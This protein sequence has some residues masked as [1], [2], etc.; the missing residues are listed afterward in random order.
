MFDQRNEKPMRLSH[1]TPRMSQPGAK[2]VAAA[3][4]RGCLRYGCV[5]ETATL[6]QRKMKS[7]AMCVYLQCDGCGKGFSSGLRKED[8]YYFQN[9]PLWDEPLRQRF[10]E[11]C[12]V[13]MDAEQ[14]RRDKLM[15][16]RQDEIDQWWFWYRFEF[17]KSDEWYALRDKVLKRDK[18]LCQ[19]CGQAQATQVHHET[20]KF[21]AEPPMKYL[22]SVC[23]ACHERVHEGWSD[24]PLPEKLKWYEIE[25]E[26]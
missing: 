15:S 2:I 4:A 5:S 19:F 1:E 21:G 11:K 13:K 14:A 12:R 18:F 8:H 25:R 10:E 24:D 23:E 7:G 3:L 22:I 17:L 16:D 26:S 6:R 20:Y 9:Y